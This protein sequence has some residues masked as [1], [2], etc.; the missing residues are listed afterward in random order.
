MFRNASQRVPDPLK[1]LT[2]GRTKQIEALQESAPMVHSAVA[3]TSASASL[4][5]SSAAISAKRPPAK[6][7]DVCE[8]AR[9]I[10]RHHCGGSRANG[11]ERTREKKRAKKREK[12][13]ETAS[14]AP[15]TMDHT[16]LEPFRS[17]SHALSP[18]SLS[19]LQSSSSSDVETRS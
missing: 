4:R 13:R 1:D 5:N 19:S 11:R 9:C 16:K 12:T 8:I 14:G 2:A 7:V 15:V 18:T 17:S 6:S 10:R 3:A